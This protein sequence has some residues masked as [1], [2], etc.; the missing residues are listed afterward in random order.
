MQK[1]SD[2]MRWDGM[3]VLLCTVLEGVS[4][5]EGGECEDDSA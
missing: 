5:C 1:K 4:I 2:G 3:S